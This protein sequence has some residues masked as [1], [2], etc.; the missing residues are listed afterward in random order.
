MYGWV[1]KIAVPGHGAGAESPTHTEPDN[2]D[3]VLAAGSVA[4]LSVSEVSA[5][6]RPY[7]QSVI[8]V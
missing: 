5:T 2:R 6:L 3:E 1:T 4:T 8:A 7:S